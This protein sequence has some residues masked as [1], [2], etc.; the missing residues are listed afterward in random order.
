[1]NPYGFDFTLYQSQATLLSTYDS[2]VNVTVTAVPEPDRL[3]PGDYVRRRASA[4]KA[5]LV[6]PTPRR[7]FRVD[8]PS[9]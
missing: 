8:Y 3:L 9:I 7:P 6:G 2:G 4:S 1:M 5:Q